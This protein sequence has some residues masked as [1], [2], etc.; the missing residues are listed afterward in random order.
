MQPRSFIVKRILPAILAALILTSSFAVAFPA[1]AAADDKNKISEET[2]MSVTGTDDFS[3]TIDTVSGFRKDR[4]VGLFYFIWFEF[5]QKNYRFD[6]TKLLRTKPEKLWDPFDKTG[7]A[8]AGCMYYFNEPL[9][10]YYKSTDKW[11]VRKHIELFIA[12]GI[13][14]L[15]IDLSN[16]VIYEDALVTLL[17]TMMGFYNAGYNVP[18]VV[19]YTNLNTG[20]T[21]D[22]L[23]KVI[24]S[25]DKYRPLWFYGPYDKPL[26][27]AHREEL[28]DK[29]NE[30]FYVRPAQWPGFEY[31][32]YEDGIP[33]CD[34]NRPQRTHQ[35]LIGVSVA[36]HTAYVFS[37]G[38]RVDP[39]DTPR[40]INHGRGYTSKT[41]TN[42]DPVAIMRGDNIEEQWDYA[43]SQDPEIIFVTGWNEWA[44]NKWPGKE[45]DTV[46]RFVDSFNTEYSRDIEMTKERRYEGD[47][48]TGYTSEGYADNFYLQ[49]VRN[50]RRYKGVK[51]SSSDM[52]V[53]PSTSEAPS[54]REYLSLAIAN[55]PRNSG[56]YKQAAADNFVRKINVSHTPDEIVFRIECE[57][58]ITA[59]A[60]GATNWMNIYF[61][62]EKSAEAKWETYSYVLNRRPGNGV[63]SLD[64]YDGNAFSPLGECALEVA[65]NV[66]TVR[67]PISLLPDVAD[68][69]GFVMDF[70]VADS[71]E[72]QDDIMDYY[73]SGSSV[74]IGRLSYTYA[75]KIKDEPV[76]K[77]GCG[78]AAGAGAS[79]ALLGAGALGAVAL[80]AAPP[81]REEASRSGKG[82]AGKEKRRKTR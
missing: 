30:F 72:V 26:M 19:C 75:A 59:P 42:G 32:V 66:M 21:V 12:A 5:A 82:K 63:T 36:Q 76:K 25:S 27:V 73:V 29:Y 70:K 64:K 77:K 34:L 16:D 62:F 81:V 22:L 61:G 7:T 4:Y 50:V 56:G 24:Y 3:R 47:A 2:V 67:V 37:Y 71:I 51:D 31:E 54:G 8:P 11:V 20:H 18:K 78:A 33:Y 69:Y 14:F 40:D 23:Y 35:N 15:A 58:G 55:E 28:A 10:G 43:I 74:P 79:S 48:E 53:E 60:E 49:L 6:T 39:H 65:D 68:A 17:D 57:N 9:Y 13:D 38:M 46:A 80:R 52:P 44:T 41:Q 1:A 45:G